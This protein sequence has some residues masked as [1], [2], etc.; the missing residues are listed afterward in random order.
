MSDFRYT[1]WVACASSVLWQMRRVDLAMNRAFGPTLGLQ[2]RLQETARPDVVPS[3]AA[4]GKRMFQKWYLAYIGSHF[5]HLAP[6]YLC[7]ATT[8]HELSTEEHLG[9]SRV[10]GLSRCGLPPQI[11]P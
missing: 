10:A 5:P 6:E 2:L 11:C 3:T 8:V 9:N 4:K 7:A 1:A